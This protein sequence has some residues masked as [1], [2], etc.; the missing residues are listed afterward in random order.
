MTI[1]DSSHLLGISINAAC[2]RREGPFAR[3]E[4]RE[5]G[6]EKAEEETDSTVLH[7]C[8]V[9]DR[10]DDRQLIRRSIR[11]LR[12]AWFRACTIGSR[13][14]RLPGKDSQGGWSFRAGAVRK[15]L[16]EP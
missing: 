15:E 5:E 14:A 16:I 11:F 9:A 6:N 10:D 1:K 2:S 12:S 3:T 13:L 7:W 8:G 4:N